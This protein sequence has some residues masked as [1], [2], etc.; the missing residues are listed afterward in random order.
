MKEVAMVTDW[1]HSTAL[2]TGASSGIG[3]E[4][5]GQLAAHGV[6]LVLVARRAERLETLRG[7]LLERHPALRVDVVPSDLAAVGATAAVATLLHEAGQ[8]IDV[9]V[10]S[11]G[12]GFHR[13]FADEPADEVAAEIALNCGALAD[14]TARFLPG[15]RQA[16]RG[17]VINVASTSAFQPVPTMAVY[18]ATKA[19]VLSFTE[20]L[21]WES[22]GSGVRV[23]ALCPGPTQTEFFDQSSAP[24]MTHGRQSAAQ[25]V[26]AALAAVDGTSPTVIPGEMNKLRTLG[27]RLMPRSVMPRLAERTV[28]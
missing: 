2:V 14:L 15:M 19:F 7:Q 28:R 9:L 13:P 11:A 17:V 6:N 26:A 22:R 21:W 12:V 16:R 8:H 24:F 25:V 5:A 1:K 10:N 3:A 20:A 27:Y 4:F 18:A 23:L